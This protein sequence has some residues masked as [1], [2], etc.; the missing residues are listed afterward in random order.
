MKRVVVLGKGQIGSVAGRALALEGHEVVY[1]DKLGGGTDT[2]RVDTEDNHALVAALSKQHPDLVIGTLPAHIGYQAAANVLGA[3]YNYIDVSFYPENIEPF[4]DIAH[5]NGVVYIPDCGLAPGLSN[6]IVGNL[7]QLVWSQT[8]QTPQTILVEVGGVAKDSAQPFGYV[9]TWN[10]QDLHAEYT[11]PARLR[12]DG[13]NIELPAFSELELTSTRLGQM[14]RFLTDGSRTL[15]TSFP[16]VPDVS[17][18]TLRWPGH[19]EAVQPLLKSNSF[20]RT[21][22]EQCSTGVEDIV[23]LRVSVDTLRY[24]IVISARNGLSAMARGTALTLAKTANWYLSNPDRVIG[25]WTMEDL[26]CEPGVLQ[27]IMDMKLKIDEV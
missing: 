26:G 27:A 18:L 17:E 13:K 10:V 15:L 23:L 24:D 1:F 7:T 9:T 8:E 5:A 12:R 2:V 16:T 6:L 20:M 25:L 11:R 21:I 19:A 3:G 14:E 22:K 4:C